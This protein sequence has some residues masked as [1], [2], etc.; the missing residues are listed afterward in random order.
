MNPKFIK[1]NAFGYEALA[2]YDYNE[3]IKKLIYVFKGCYDYELKDVFLNRFINYLKVRFQGYI[4]VPIPS[5]KIDDEKRGF[6]HVYEIVKTLGLPIEKILIKKK[7]IK[8]SSLKYKDRLK[9]RSNLELK[10]NINIKNKKVLIVDDVFTSG[11]TIYHALSLVKTLSPK[12]IKILV[13]SKTID[14]DKRNKNDN[15]C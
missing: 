10:P 1:F 7:N 12:T 5:H 4:V 13:V 8:Q 9:S 14:L 15:I 11:S 6:N 2:I 3:T